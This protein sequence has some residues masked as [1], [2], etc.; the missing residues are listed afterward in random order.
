MNK[1][2]Q[3]ATV[4]SLVEDGENDEWVKRIRLPIAIVQVFPLDHDS[5]LLSAP[6]VKMYLSEMQ[7]HS[8]N[9]QILC[10]DENS[11]IDTL[12]DEE[13][14]HITKPSKDI[15]SNIADAKSIIL[16]G[17]L[18]LRHEFNSSK[19]HLIEQLNDHISKTNVINS[20]SAICPVPIIKIPS[21][22]PTAAAGIPCLVRIHSSVLMTRGK[23]LSS[24]DHTYTSQEDTSY[25]AYLTDATMV[26]I[27]PPLE[28]VTILSQLSIAVINYVDNSNPPVFITSNSLHHHILGEIDI[29]TR[30]LITL[31]SDATDDNVLFCVDKD[32]ID[33]LTLRMHLL[34][35][36]TVYIG[37]TRDTFHNVHEKLNHRFN[38]RKSIQRFWRIKN[39]EEEEYHR[40]TWTTKST[41]QLNYTYSNILSTMNYGALTV[42]NPHAAS[43]KTTL[44]SY[45][46]RKILKCNRVHILNGAAIFAKYG[47][48]SADSALETMIH[49]LI[50]STAVECHGSN[51]SIQRNNNTDIDSPHSP[52]E[53]GTNIGSICIILDHLESFVSSRIAGSDYNGS[54]DPFDPALT[55]IGELIVTFTFYNLYQAFFRF[56]CIES[57]ISYLL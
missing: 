41:D 9:I 32:L 40:R 28:T 24:V 54:K 8:F 34:L 7:G 31:E 39:K 20:F 6:F 10:D 35:S 16:H 4:S 27:C 30:K 50:L 12:W 45:I 26:Q 2:Q 17:S 3:D 43:G 47:T 52:L 13:I 37:T 25:C 51:S 1:L 15:V 18:Y 38:M 22:D 55:A 48:S 23:H 19:E 36:R 14:S 42:Y 11:L 5:P 44:V 21:E 49:S 46:A 57:I 53:S 29:S 33:S 56:I